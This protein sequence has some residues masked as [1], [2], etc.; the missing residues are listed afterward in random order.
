MLYQETHLKAKAG[1]SLTP[2]QGQSEFG[3]CPQDA[4]SILF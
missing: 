1:A 4:L 3:P 2:T